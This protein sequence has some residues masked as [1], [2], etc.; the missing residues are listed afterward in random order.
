MPVYENGKDT[1][2]R[3]LD[4]ARRLY[5]LKGPSKVTN[6]QI[7]DEACIQ[8]S[9][10]TYYFKN[11]KSILH[12]LSFETCTKWQQIANRICEHREDLTAIVY[13][14]LQY[15]IIASD[16]RSFRLFN[17]Y[18]YRYNLMN[19]TNNQNF[20][21]SY[22]ESLRTLCGETEPVTDI[23]LGIEN[24]RAICINASRIMLQSIHTKESDIDYKYIAKWNIDFILWTLGI[25]DREAVD[26]AFSEAVEIFEQADL[27]RY[28][29]SFT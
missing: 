22:I 4:A 15:K 8:L 26:E 3:I 12:D 21:F 17:E 7:A 25:Q 14:L 24:M 9:S 27:S 2:Q 10:L 23:P 1:Y 11:K 19:D 29:L 5:Y 16:Y 28:D 20:Y 18:M 6:A 13:Y